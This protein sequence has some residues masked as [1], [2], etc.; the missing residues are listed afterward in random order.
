[1][2][3][4]MSRVHIV[5]VSGAGKTTFAK[6][7]YRVVGLPHTEI[8]NLYWDKNWQPKDNK[9]FLGELSD[10]LDKEDWVIDGNYFFVEGVTEKIWARAE[11]IIFIDVPLSLALWSVTKRA[12]THAATGQTLCNRNKSSLLRF[13]SPES[14][15]LRV[16]KTRS[17]TISDFQTHIATLQKCND[18]EKE[19]ITFSGRADAYKYLE[20]LDR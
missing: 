17:S 18:G 2:E 15:A 6:E 4:V 13:F 11:K 16:L 8:D 10:T 12:F 7:F 20:T 9:S 5:G 19:I 1:V 14:I 3:Q